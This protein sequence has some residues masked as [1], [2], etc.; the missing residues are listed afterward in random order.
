M[1]D[2]GSV[3]VIALECEGRKSTENPILDDGDVRVFYGLNGCEASD[4]SRQIK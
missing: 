2:D 3:G 1:Q 4:A